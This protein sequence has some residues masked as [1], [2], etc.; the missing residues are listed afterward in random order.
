ML[1]SLTNVESPTS[2]LQLQIILFFVSLY[3]VA[4]G[5]GGHKPCFQAFGADQFDEQNPQEYND[6]STFFNWWY[7]A[8][9]AGCMVTISILNYVQDNISWVIG[10][11]IPCV[12][13]IISVLI[14][15][16]GTT[17]YRFNIQ[18]RCDESPFLRIGR[19]IVAAIRNRPSNLSCTIVT[20]ETFGIIPHQSSSSEQFE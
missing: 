18:G 5:Q 8:L 17:S 9:C 10:Y 11:G 20:K 15:L 1:P 13:M 12:A 14:F 19:V 2:G 3:L 16:L 6:R 4:I 7:F